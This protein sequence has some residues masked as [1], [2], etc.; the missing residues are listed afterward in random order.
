MPDVFAV[1][2]LGLPLPLNML[3][4]AYDAR[5]SSYAESLPSTNASLMSGTSILRIEVQ[6]QRV[7][8]G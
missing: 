2:I 4:A 6:L 7:L 1:V 3:W 5:I 8:D